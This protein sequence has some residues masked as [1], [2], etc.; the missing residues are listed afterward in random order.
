M[1]FFACDLE[2]EGGFSVLDVPIS[3]AVITFFAWPL[4]LIAIMEYVKHRDIR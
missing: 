2:V 1:I 4:C 3:V